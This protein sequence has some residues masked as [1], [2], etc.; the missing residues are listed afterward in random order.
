MSLFHF[1]HRDAMLEGGTVPTDYP[2]DVL[3]EI[4]FGPEDAFGITCEPRTVAARGTAAC[5][6]WDRN[7]GVVRFEAPII[8]KLNGTW[9]SEQLKGYLSGNFLQ[10]SRC[11]NSVNEAVS[12]AA[13][14]N[15][16]LPALLSFRFRTF[17]WIKEFWIQLGDAR[18]RFA[19][20]DTTINIPASTTEENK[21]RVWTCL[22]EWSRSNSKHR[23][24][25]GA[26]YYYRQALRLSQLQLDQISL[27]PEVVL[28]LTKAIEIIFGTNREVA[29]KK[30]K[31]MGLTDEEIE[32]LLIPILLI[33]S[34][35]DIAHVATGPLS[36]K[37]RQIIVDFS[38]RATTGVGI[39]LDRVFQA[40]LTGEVDLE[41]TS[42][43]L[44]KDK[45]KLIEALDRYNREKANKTGH[46]AVA[47][48]NVGP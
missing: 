33:R 27:T 2:C 47:N 24:L 18:F 6:T 8:E 12:F 11:V 44:D 23:R 26:I 39:I 14:A 3:L 20:A 36:P 16:C 34:S 9:E 38:S 13:S 21:Q 42:P 28:N 46:S 17:V 1:Q 30:A 5:I 15:Q 41:R 32:K 37:E 4:R 22:D 48:N 29:R 25:V 40:G 10:L 43:T 35:L 31:S 7:E 45:K 19:L